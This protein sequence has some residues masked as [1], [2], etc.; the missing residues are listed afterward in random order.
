MG[1]R[2]ATCSAT[3]VAERCTRSPESVGLGLLLASST[4]NVLVS[5]SRE[6]GGCWY[7]TAAIQG[8]DGG[9]R[10]EI[11]QQEEDM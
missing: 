7:G 10:G 6:G 5:S 11:E 3:L 2:L 4:V 9:Y 8:W 1:F